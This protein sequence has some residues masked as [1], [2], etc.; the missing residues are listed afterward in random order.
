MTHEPKFEVPRL[1]VNKGGRK[2]ELADRKKRRTVL[3]FIERGMTFVLAAEAVGIDPS[4]L[5]AYRRKNPAFERQVKKAGARGIESRLKKIEKASN[6]GDWRA[7]A[8][9]LEH[10]SPENFARNRI[11][12]TGAN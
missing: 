4:T 7:S 9:L 11:E 5:W 2:T 12:V 6:S 8:W 10:C 3:R 1:P